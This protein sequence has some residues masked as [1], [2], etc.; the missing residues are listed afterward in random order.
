MELGSYLFASDAYLTE[1][2]KHGIE[3]GSYLF[4]SD[5]EETELG[6]HR[7]RKGNLRNEKGK[8]GN[9]IPQAPRENL[10]GRN[11]FAV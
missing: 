3:L 6:K 1:L 8:T 10:E 9:F 4:S 5:K 7:T 11:G 2:G